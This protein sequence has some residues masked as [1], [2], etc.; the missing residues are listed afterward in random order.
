MTRMKSLLASSA[1]AIALAFGGT[2][3]AQDFP[4]QPIEMTI[5]FGSTAQTIGQLLAELMSEHLDERV[6]PVP[7]PGGGGSVGYQH[8]QSAPADGHSIVSNS[9]SISTSY[10]SGAIDFDYTAFEPIAR[11]STEV[12]AVAVNPDSGWE[13]LSDMAA[14]IKEQ[15]RPLRVGASGR[16]SFTH[17]ATAAMLESL[18]LSDQAIHVPFDEGRA[19][20][21]LLAGRIDAAIQWPGQFISHHNAGN[22]TILCVTGAERIAMLPDV[23]TCEE[24]G[25]EGFE[26]TMWRGLAA[27]S[28]TPEAAIDA[29]EEAA[30]LAVEDERFQEAAQTVGFQPDFAPSEEFGEQIAQDDE[31]LAALMSRLGL[32]EQ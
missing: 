30:R 24:S 27:P 8:V 28:G 3:Q 12:A 15:G 32:T 10:H 19:P 13:S 16:G 7:R 31:R 29:L 5:L 6:V 26:M 22:L 2:A 25:A 20:V 4:S 11:V 21:E 18:G 17:L 14:D 23:P 9:N 1:A